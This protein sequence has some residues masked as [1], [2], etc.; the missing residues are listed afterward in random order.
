MILPHLEAL[1]WNPTVLAVRPESI[2]CPQD[3]LLELTLPD[4]LHVERVSALPARWT[5]MAGVGSLS[6]R[7]RF[8]V[9]RGGRELLRR[10]QFDLVFFSTTEFPLMSFGRL[11]QRQYG[12][13]YVL[14]MQDPWANEYYAHHPEAKPPGGRIKHAVTQWLA[15]RCEP[16]VMR[17][18]AH[19]ICVS[20]SY[21]EMLRRRCQQ[22]PTSHFTVLPFAAA[23]ADFELLQRLSVTQSCFD[24]NDGFHH[25]VY[26]GAISPSMV[27]PA[28]SFLLALSRVVGQ[29]PS[30]RKRL[31]VHFIGTNYSTRKTVKSPI[32]SAASDCGVG[33]MVVERPERL[34]YFQALRCLSDAHAL[35]VPGSEDAGYTAS[36]LYPYILAR[37][38][39]LA[40]FHAQSSVV[41]VLEETR[42]G[43]AVIFSGA[44][45]AETIS[46]RIELAWFNRRPLLVPDVDWNAFRPYTAHEMT[47]KIALLFDQVARRQTKVRTHD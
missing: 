43:T 13:P 42:A 19:V 4:G 46:R 21:P 8:F 37:K 35:I 25:W 15:R 39:L 16:T 1:G 12:I 26:V 22:I 18:A 29:D 14:D 47:R 24:P 30:L 20:P 9:A 28:R 5:R 3:P 36:K 44:D 2:E 27:M 34:P 31:R 7:S 33:D 45:D 6:L 32:K 38:P 17:E 10:Q 11:W 41:K 40:V 23:E